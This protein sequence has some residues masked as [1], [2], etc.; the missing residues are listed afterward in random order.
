MLGRVSSV[1][2]FGSIVLLPIA[3]LI[4]AAVV[5]RV[6]PEGAFVIGGGL[7]AALCL[8]ALAVRSIRDLE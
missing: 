4:F 3:P 5:E 2:G 7:S 1:D 8:A 6:G